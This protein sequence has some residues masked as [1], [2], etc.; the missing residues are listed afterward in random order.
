MTQPAGIEKTRTR[1][2]KCFSGVESADATVS[3]GSFSTA[4]EEWFTT[5]YWTATPP[6][7]C[8]RLPA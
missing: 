8:I 3:C 4:W 6:P 1:V 5:C 2:Q 7:S